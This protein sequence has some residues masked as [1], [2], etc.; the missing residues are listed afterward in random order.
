MQ[1][2]LNEARPAGKTMATKTI[3]IGSG[4]WAKRLR[5]RHARERRFRFYTLFAT[6][7]GISFV[8]VLFLGIFLNGYTAFAQTY[9][10]LPVTF[11]VELLDVEPDPSGGYPQDALFRANYGALS[12]ASLRARFPDVTARRDKKML[13]AL[14]SSG[15]AFELRDRVLADPG[16]LGS[17]R[18]IRLT[19]D[20][21]VDMLM[22][23]YT[24]RDGPETARRIKDRQLVWLDAL[25]EEG[26]IG[27]R[28]NKGFFSGGDSREPE[29]AGIRGAVMGSAFTLL[30]TLLLSFPLGVTAAV[31]LE[32]FA[33]KGRL[34]DLI[35]VNINNL[36]AVPSVVFGL[37]GLAVF[38]NFFQLPRSIPLVGGIVMTLMTMPTIIIAG[39]AALLSVPP[40]IREAALGV[41]ASKTQMIVHHVLPLAMPGMLTGA[42]IGMARALGETAP[43]LMIGMVAFI[44][45]IPQG[46][47]DPA[48]VLPVQI[49]LWAD[50]PERAF[51]ER[52]SAAIMVLLV[53]LV[54]MNAAAIWL[55]NHFEKRW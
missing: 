35:E 9:I 16:I 11:D 45:D 34:T 30:V 50:S 13:Y 24:D 19:T 17:T 33:P 53:F 46:I 42:I 49:F 40:S 7:L 38:I 54:T 39:R 36:A 10:R 12:K 55:R 31:Y 14:I 25:A 22:K 5:K 23:G 8:F 26:A 43:L 20:D 4:N 1:F 3:P 47:T 2:P 41:G 28:F 37:L 52:T 18:E 32:E 27:K 44:V 51:V 6:L 29:L 15:A 21:E 48:T